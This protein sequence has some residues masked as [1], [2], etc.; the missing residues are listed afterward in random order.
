MGLTIVEVLTQRIPSW[1]REAQ[2]DPGI[3]A[4]LPQ[5]LFDIVRN[6]LRR[7]A[8]RRLTVKQITARLNTSAAASAN[9]TTEIASPTPTVA[10]TK[11]IGSSSSSPAAAAPAIRRAKAPTA[12]SVSPRFEAPQPKPSYTHNAAKVPAPPFRRQCRGTGKSHWE[13]LDLR[14]QAPKPFH[15]NAIRPTRT[16]RY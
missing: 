2:G 14:N 8:R 3:T 7:D 13:N 6:C 5:P 12:E 11:Q 16:S 1:E 15:S 10:E 4:N 9:S